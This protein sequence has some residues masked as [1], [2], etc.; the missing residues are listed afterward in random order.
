MRSLLSLFLL[1]SLIFP[2][3]A[4]AQTTSLSIWPPLLE[5]MIR[6]GKSIT[7]VYRLKNE[8]DAT[9]VTVSVVPFSP[10]DELGHIELQFGGR[11]P[12]Y[13]SLLNADLPDL[14]VTLNL[15][16]GQS[17]ELVLKI[18]IPNEAQDADYP[19]ALVIESN[20]AGLIGGSGTVTQ[21]TIAA[22]IL[23]SVSQSGQPPRLAQIVEFTTAR[24]IDSFDPIEF[25]LRVKNQSFT[26][27][28]PV[29]QI[30]INN[31]F[32]RTVATIPLQSDH[33][34]GGTIRQLKMEGSDPS[35]FW[36][37]VLPF[38]RYQAVA[39]ITPLDTTNT[40]SQTLVFWVLPYKAL[41]VLCLIYLGYRYLTIMLKQQKLKP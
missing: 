21:A 23:L 11:L 22:P 1:T 8:A 35:I 15:D 30:K 5:T 26:R 16:A 10:S 12:D 27:L 20:S 18:A 29:G 19:V 17:Q 7:Q 38:G 4:A 3:A 31:S 9:T 33:I 13:F 32:G 34:L 36:A 25:I 39:E 28:Q 24:L 14:P 41:L 37:P 2:A 6:P 40:V